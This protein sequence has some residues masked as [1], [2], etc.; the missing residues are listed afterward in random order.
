MSP[1]L[2]P[3]HALT[4]LAASG[5]VAT[6]KA[7]RII[8][9]PPTGEDGLP[10]DVKVPV[11]HVVTRS[12]RIGHHIHGT[13]V[14]Y[15]KMMAFTTVSEFTDVKG[16]YRD[17]HQS[18]SSPK[19]RDWDPV[20]PD[21]D[22]MESAIRDRIT[23]IDGQLTALRTPDDVSKYLDGV[24]TDLRGA[25]FV[26]G[27]LVWE[28]YHARGRQKGWQFPPVVTEFA[29]NAAARFWAKRASRES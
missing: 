21:D 25:G 28:F 23:E 11:P 7:K 24:K 27:S 5:E 10:E 4:F 16:E 12:A 20:W 8:T 18:S 6:A 15:T 29:S 26:P 13:D 3:H 1:H 17:L 9:M 22:A 14:E 2:G 19:S